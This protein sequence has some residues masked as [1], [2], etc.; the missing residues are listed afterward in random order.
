M[1]RS[2]GAA[3]HMTRYLKGLF[4]YLHF[5]PLTNFSKEHGLEVSDNSIAHINI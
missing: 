5:R 1:T 3:L 4:I 2:L